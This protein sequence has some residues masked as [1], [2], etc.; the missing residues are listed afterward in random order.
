MINTASQTWSL[1]S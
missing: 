1:M